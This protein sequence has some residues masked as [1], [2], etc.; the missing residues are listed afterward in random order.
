MSHTNAAGAGA[1]VLSVEEAAAIRWG[2][3]LRKGVSEK[4]PVS[5]PHTESALS[6]FTTLRG[7]NGARGSMFVA[8][9]LNDH[10]PSSNLPIACVKI[11]DIGS[12]QSSLGGHVI[13][14]T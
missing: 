10:Q 7:I 8:D 6:T 4:V 11:D 13:E 2:R 3:R 14:W 1:C 9:P 5:P 12:Q